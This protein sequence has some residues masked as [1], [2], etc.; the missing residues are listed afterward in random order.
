MLYPEEYAKFVELI[1]LEERGDIVK[2][3]YK[4]LTAPVGDAQQL[5]CA[6][7]WN[8]YE[9][10]LSSMQLTQEDVD[11]CQDDNWNLAH[12]RIECHYFVNK[13]YLEESQL[14]N[15]AVIIAKSG[16]PVEIVQG[17]YD[18][19]CPVKVTLLLNFLVILLNKIYFKD[20]MGLAQTN[21]AI[22]SPYFANGWSF[23]PR[24]WDRHDSKA[25]GY[26]RQV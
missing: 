1:P 11:K 17:R 10:T 22:N 12:A 19:A 14:I 3:Y 7:A 9:L 23:E 21:S 18:L 2:A 16:V 25:S 13:G 26:L 6:T 8:I 4:R 5:K 20:G 24:T 15:D